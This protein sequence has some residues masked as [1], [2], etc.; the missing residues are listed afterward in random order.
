MAAAAGESH[1]PQAMTSVDPAA[2]GAAD[3][4]QVVHDMDS[5]AVGTARRPE[6]AS[7][8]CQAGSSSWL[9][10][11]LIAFSEKS[12]GPDCFLENL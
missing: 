2:A 8:P 7:L 12:Q 4:P 1:Q 9:R 5:A 10:G 11:D 6:E 3:R